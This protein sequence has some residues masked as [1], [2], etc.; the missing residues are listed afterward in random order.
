[1]NRLG[2]LVDISHVAA[3]T[4]RD[5]LAVTKSPVMFSHSNAYGLCNHTRNVP[6]D[7]LLKLVSF[8]FSFEYAVR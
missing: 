6:D 8:R 1:M 7:V 5:V 4:M 3:A 2:M